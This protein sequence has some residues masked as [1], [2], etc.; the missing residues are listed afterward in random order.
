MS[1][2][3]W[4]DEETELARRLLAEKASDSEFMRRLG[5]AKISARERLYRVD[6]PRGDWTSLGLPR[7]GRVE[8]P[9]H[10][11]ADAVRRGSAPRT[12]T[13]WLCNDP[14]PGQS[15]LDKRLAGGDRHAR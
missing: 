12:L 2:K 1:G 9:S 13:A 8:V 10:V 14:A 5:R 11:T 3:P 15:A 7:D 6:F 4:S